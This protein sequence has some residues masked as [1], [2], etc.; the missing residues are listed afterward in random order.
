MEILFPHYD[1]NA[2]TW[3]YLSLLLILAVFFRFN[4]VFS[5]R[6]L[7]LA[8][9]LSLSPGLLLV[10]H[11]PVMGYAWLFFVTAVLL[12]RLFC[13]P[14]LQRRPRLD[15]NLNAAGLTFLCFACFAFLTT[16]ILTR[17]VP[18][19]IVDTV[20]RGGQLLNRQDASADSAQA[21][22]GPTSSLL[23]AQVMPLSSAMA[24]S[25]GGPGSNA[26]GAE[27][28]AARAMA[29]VAH[30]AVILGLFLIGQQLFR[31]S[32]IGLAMATLYLLLPCTAYKVGE[33]N[34][35]LPAA[36]IVWAFVA[37][38][39]PLVSGSLMGLAC[40]TLLFPVF[41]LP[42][43]FTFYGRRGAL[44]FGG[45]LAGVAGLLLGSLALVSSDPAS[46]VSQALRMVNWSA[47]RFSADGAPSGFWT[48]DNAPYRL[49]VLVGYLVMVAVLTIWP[50]RKNLEHLMAHSAALVVG[51]QF[52]YPQ[53]G[54][55]YLLWYLP[56]LLMVVFR[57]RLAH[58]TPPTFERAAAE[59]KPVPEPFSRELVGSSVGP[60]TLFR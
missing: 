37:Y 1:L 16:S 41:L 24:S 29:I 17:P 42:L 45:A 54:G 20:R 50:R 48:L 58:L 49:P 39:R 25:R 51:T 59:R 2:A 44:R 60:R 40:G 11:R 35:V 13:D 34:H 18:P 56:L 47:M 36:L 3:F 57:P 43:W 19:S 14:L 4:R 8:L 32:Q 7:D 28:I 33:V 5:L 26:R 27:I 12:F 52:W 31:E 9:L 23:A 22:A 53:Q 15:Q 55:V 30:L 38:R 21:E 46:F 10:E 6:N